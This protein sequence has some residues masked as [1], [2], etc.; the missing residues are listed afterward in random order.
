MGLKATALEQAKLLELVR[1]DNALAGVAR[2]RREAQ[3]AANVRDSDAT[4]IDLMRAAESAADRVDDL[5]RESEHV[6]HD[7]AVAMA[8]IERDR[9]LESAEQSAKDVQALEHEIASL[10]IRV[11][12]LTDQQ[13]VILANLEDATRELLDAR[14]ARDG[15][16]AEQ[17]FGRA[18]AR[19]TV[20]SL[21]GIEAE[22]RA[23]RR[24]VISSIPADLA[25]LYE[26]QFERYGYGASHL[27]GYVTSAT[28]V[29]LTEADLDR[30]R[31]ASSDDV[32]MCPDSNAILVRTKDSGL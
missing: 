17:E 30:I 20:T 15:Y 8:R 24:Q 6:A 27:Q 3:D 22:L 29:T 12:L 9:S 23:E 1:I 19:A 14:I 28:G 4:Y 26:R 21:D 25:A 5:T 2:R 10:E 11:S 32:L 18:D 7:I 16:H 13:A 31:R